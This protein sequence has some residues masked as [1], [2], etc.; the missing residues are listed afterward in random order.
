[1]IR[2]LYVIGLP[3][4]NGCLECRAGAWGALDRQR[5]SKRA[6]SLRGRMEPEPVYLGRRSEGEAPA[7]IGDLQQQFA[8]LAAQGQVDAARAGMPVPVVEGFL[9]D[10]IEAQGDIERN[11][12]GIALIDQAQVHAGSLVDFLALQLER[13]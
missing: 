7:M 4:R 2:G 10:P 8:S 9:R 5:A 1:M 13:R 11:G 3:Q 12:R 6:D